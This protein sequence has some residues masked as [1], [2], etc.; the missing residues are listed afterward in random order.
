MLNWLERNPHF[1][2]LQVGHTKLV[3]S[4]YL[5]Q[6][7]G[8]GR[9]LAI[10]FLGGAGYCPSAWA[11]RMSRRTVNWPVS[12]FRGFTVK[13]RLRPWSGKPYDP[14]GCMYRRRRIAVTTD[15]NWIMI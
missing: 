5:T 3:H 6:Y 8:P 4:A 9:V 14:T 7:A 11:A 13:L 12:P 10:S 2:R 15:P 1:I